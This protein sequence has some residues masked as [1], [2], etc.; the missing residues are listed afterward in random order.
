MDFVHHHRLRFAGM[1]LRPVR[2][3][4][5]QAHNQSPNIDVCELQAERDKLNKRVHSLQSGLHFWLHFISR[6]P[7]DAESAKSTCRGFIGS[8]RQIGFQ[9]SIPIFLS[10]LIVYC[11]IL[12]VT[13]NPGEIVKII[14][15]VSCPTSSNIF[16][17]NPTCHN[18]LQRV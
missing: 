8:F 16:Y 3:H 6:L 7:S 11:E 4:A 5:C 14:D 17:T 18:F 13:S 12:F 9:S 2:I 1:P 15:S 10:L